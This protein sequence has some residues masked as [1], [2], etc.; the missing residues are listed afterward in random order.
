MKALI[1]NADDLGLTSGVTRGIIDAHLKGV[2]TSTSALMNS[3]IIAEGL[4][5]ARQKAPSLGI[6]VHLV[7]TWGKPMLL[8]REIPGLVDD[9]GDFCKFDQLA[10]RVENLNSDEVRKE[11]RTQIEAFL[12]NRLQPD[13]LDSHHHISYSSE[14]LFRIMLDL[15]REYDLPIRY[16]SLPDNATAW[17][18]FPAALVDQYSIR[19]PQN[20][21]VSFYGQA[22]SL[23]NLVEILSTLP[24]GVS[25]LM[26]H[27]GYADRELMEGSSYN[28]VREKE[29]QLLVSPEIKAAVEKNGVI[30]SRFSDL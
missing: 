21:I 16:P 8:P 3:P 30:L 2:V 1:I 27:P 15:A 5:M 26:C 28:T 17:K 10:R 19:S 6:G 11:W 29:F 23:T 7:L 20:C 25:E 13:H 12:A 24:K 14:S 4:A 22:V 9:H 18:G